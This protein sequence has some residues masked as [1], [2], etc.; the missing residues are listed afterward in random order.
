MCFLRGPERYGIVLAGSCI[1]DREEDFVASELRN[2]R[3]TMLIAPEENEMRESF[4]RCNPR[5][6]KKLL[7]RAMLCVR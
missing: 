7:R 1:A 3:C 4:S 2:I 6:E 5:V